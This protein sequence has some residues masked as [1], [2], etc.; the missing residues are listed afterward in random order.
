MADSKENRDL[1]LAGDRVKKPSLASHL[2]PQ[3][4]QG[5]NCWDHLWCGIFSELLPRNQWKN[6]IVEIWNNKTQCLHLLVPDPSI[7]LSW[8]ENPLPNHSPSSIY[9]MHHI[10]SVSQ[11]SSLVST[12][13]KNLLLMSKLLKSKPV[14]HSQEHCWLELSWESLCFYK[15]LD[16]LCHHHISLN[17]FHLLQWKTSLSTIIKLM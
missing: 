4:L 5:N 17:K 13:F 11:N 2:H 7:L 14:A 15:V 9:L 10:N 6:I 12:S 1:E 16:P 3:L 8:T